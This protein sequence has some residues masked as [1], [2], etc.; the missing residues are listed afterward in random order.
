MAKLTLSTGSNRGDRA[1][2]LNRAANLLESRIGPIVY[3]SPV[4]ETAAWGLPD[5]ADFLNQILVIDTR[6]PCRGSELVPELH[7]LLDVTQ[8]IELE[9]GRTREVH[10]GPRTVDI[11]LIFVDDLRYEDARLS[12][13]H[14]WWRHRLFVTELLPEDPRFL[15]PYSR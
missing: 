11:D 12:L 9:L 2:L 13:P 5:Q 6:R 15:P 8:A 3:R 7:R 1:T 14:P 10:W 4:R